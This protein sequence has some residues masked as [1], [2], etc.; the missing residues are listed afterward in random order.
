METESS[1]KYFAIGDQDTETIK[2]G[3]V[4]ETNQA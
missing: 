4:E 1:T 3:P 2:F